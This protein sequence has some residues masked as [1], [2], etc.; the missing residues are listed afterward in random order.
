MTL[1]VRNANMILVGA[2][3]S[4]YGCEAA[5]PWERISEDRREDRELCRRLHDERSRASSEWS[6]K[7]DQGPRM[8]GDPT[9][10]PP[11]RSGRDKVTARIQTG[12]QNAFRYL[13]E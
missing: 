7:L 9:V 12:G 6:I 5:V 1:V 4:H 3:V 2:S 10:R 13:W 8:S 11:P